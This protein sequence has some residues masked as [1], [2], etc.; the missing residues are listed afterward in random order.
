MPVDF[1]AAGPGHSLSQRCSPAV[2]AAQGQGR[3]LS[4]AL[5]P[6]PHQAAQTP[7]QWKTRC[8]NIRGGIPHRQ[9]LPLWGR[10]VSPF[11]VHIHPVAASLLSSTQASLSVSLASLCSSSY[12]EGYMDNRRNPSY[13][14]I[15]HILHKQVLGFFK[16]SSYYLNFHNHAIS[17]T[18]SCTDVFTILRFLISYI[19][20]GWEFQIHMGIYFPLILHGYK[21]QKI[22]LSVFLGA[23]YF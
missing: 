11:W 19:E 4:F 15:F 14:V 13:D 1:A 7:D 5:E 3:Y 21:Q 20:V 22:L 12:Q 6:L 10:D 2:A 16:R 18:I 8:T 23:K 9:F 17:K